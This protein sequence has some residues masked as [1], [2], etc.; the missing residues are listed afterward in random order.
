MERPAREK[1][2]RSVSVASSISVDTISTTATEDATTQQSHQ[3]TPKVKRRRSSGS[4]TGSPHSTL[5]SG[6]DAGDGRAD[7]RL[8]H[9][10]IS[11]SSPSSRGRSP[12]RNVTSSNE[13][14]NENTK[15]LKGR[16]VRDR[17]DSSENLDAGRQRRDVAKD[18]D[19]RSVKE[20]GFHRQ[21]AGNESS[22][23]APRRSDVQRE[24]SLSPF[25]KR[26]ALTKAMDR[27]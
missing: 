8:V 15:A 24:R 21:S 22:G 5:E 14:A 1:R 2:H 17:W 10:R 3:R 11:R 12:S 19:V 26:L 4:F 27:G 25:S 7:S 6:K 20:S 13:R 18:I 16:A 9:Q 23:H